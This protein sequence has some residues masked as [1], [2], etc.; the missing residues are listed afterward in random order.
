MAVVLKALKVKETKNKVRYDLMDTLTKEGFYFRKEW[1]LDKFVRFPEV[2][3]MTI[4]E[5][6]AKL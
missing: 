4:D 5:K 2:I 3:Y 6:E 1:L